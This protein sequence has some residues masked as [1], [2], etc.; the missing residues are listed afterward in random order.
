MPFSLVPM[1]KEKKV[2]ITRHTMPHPSPPLSSL[3]VNS[4]QFILPKKLDFTLNLK[5]PRN[6]GSG[7]ERPTVPFHTHCPV[8][9]SFTLPK[10]TTW[11]DND[12][13]GYKKSRTAAQHAWKTAFFQA[14]FHGAK[15][16][17]GGIPKTF[18][19]K[20]WVLPKVCGGLDWGSRTKGD[21]GCWHLWPPVA[22]GWGLHW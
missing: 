13:T 6:Q 18:P 1:T 5:Q 8:A 17:P 16:Q 15:H 10:A 19:L 12:R 9:P 14:R 21:T 2:K 20:P 22:L 4:Q 3:S 7:G 11:M